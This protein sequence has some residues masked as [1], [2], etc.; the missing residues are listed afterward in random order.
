MKEILIY[1]AGGFGMEVAFLLE[2]IN[3]VSPTWKIA[4]YID[5]F[6][7]KWGKSFYG[8]PVVGGRQFLMG[9]REKIAV[10]VAIGSPQIRAD[11]VMAITR[12]NIEFPLLIHPGVTMSRSVK[13]GK[14]SIVCAGSILTV[15]ITVGDHV[16]VN[17]DCT[18]GHGAMVADYVTL[19]PSVN[20]SGDATIGRCT[21]VGTGCQI[22]EGVSIGENVVLGAGTVVIQDI[23][24]D[25]TAVGVPAA[26]KTKPQPE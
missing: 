1:G 14:G 17:L 13:V 15:E 19:N 20:V 23:P 22:I 12:E 6:E 26:V 4:G 24:S 11:V 2:Q 25:C 5:D 8:Y 3:E 18:I 16:H 7:E 9:I 21:N 10:A